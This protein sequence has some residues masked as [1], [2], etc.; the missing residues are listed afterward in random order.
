M[1]PRRLR[2]LLDHLGPRDAYEVASG[3]TPPT[4]IVGRLLT[5]ELRGWWRQSAS[6]RSPAICCEQ[7]VEAGVDV[8]TVHDPHFP[9]L[10]RVDPSPP[11]V[12]FVRGDLAVL[13]ARRVGI[14]GTRNATLMGRQ[15]ATELGFDLAA[16]GVAVVSGLAKGIDGAAHRGALTAGDSDNAGVGRPVAVVGNGADRPYPKQHADLWSAVCAR[17]LLMSEWPPGTPPEAFHF[18]MRNRILAALCEVL[19]VVES[20]ER[21]GSLLTVREAL[22]RSVEVMAVPGSP[23]NRAAAGTN[24]LLRDGAAPVTSADDVLASLGLDTRRQGAVVFDPRPAL[25]GVDR[26][27]VEQCRADPRTLDDVASACG[28]ALS[29]AAIT[30][31]RLERAGWLREVGGWFEAIWSRAEL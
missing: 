28:L 25:R 11:T 21:G 10:L 20:R 24:G 12:L 4:P 7:C 27:V 31:A 29:E 1:T 23:R 18:P 17:G 8:V 26:V 14:V 9:A 13:D 15:T 5:D 16:A 2:I 19:V 3:A 22:D 30:L 6:E